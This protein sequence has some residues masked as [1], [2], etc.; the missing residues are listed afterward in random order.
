MA[1]GV[2]SLLMNLYLLR[3]DYV[4]ITLKGSNDAKV[5]YHVVLEKS[6]SEYLPEEFQ[7]LIVEAE[8]ATLRKCLSVMMSY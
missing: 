5:S 7:K 3:N 8:V 4:I 1:M 6:H 2:L